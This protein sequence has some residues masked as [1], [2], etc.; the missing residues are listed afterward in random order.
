MANPI[1]YRYRYIRYYIMP[2]A[3]FTQIADKCNANKDKFTD[4]E[5]LLIYGYFK[6]ATVGDVNVGPSADPVAQ[7]KYEAWAKHKGLSKTDAEAAYIKEGTALL[8]K[9]GAL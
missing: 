3:E 4:P 8:K 5:R 7:A 9:V 2:S 6:Q 1:R